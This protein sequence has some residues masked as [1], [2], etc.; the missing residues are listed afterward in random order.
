LKLSGIKLH[1]EIEFF[2]PNEEE[3]MEPVYE[4]ARRYH[5]P[6]IFHS[7]MSS[8]AAPAVIGELASQYRDVPVILGHMGV[9][10]YVK[11]AVAVA[12]QNKNIYLETS[13]VG[14]MPLIME[15]FNRVETSKMLYGSDHP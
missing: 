9:S 2:D 10:E 13:V 7:G 8:K 14:W 11:Q 1:P 15:A 3:L 6:V 5:V 12:R 4:A